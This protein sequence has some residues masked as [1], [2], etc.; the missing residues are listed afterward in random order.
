MHLQVE[1][2]L[3][4]Y[5]PYAADVLLAIEAAPMEEQQ[6]ITD[7]LRVSGVGPLRTVPGDDGIGRRTMDLR[8]RA[9]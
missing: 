5:M 7:K 8:E 6:L 2:Q 9:V 4:Y 3:S 1:A